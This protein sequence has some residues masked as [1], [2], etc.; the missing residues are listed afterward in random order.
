M[1]DFLLMSRGSTFTDHCDQVLWTLEELGWSINFEKSLIM[2]KSKVTYLGYKVTSQGQ[3][4]YPEVAVTSN[5]I[6]KLIHPITARRLASI[7][8]ALVILPA[9]LLLRSCYRLLHQRNNWE[10]PLDLSTDVVREL[11]WWLDYV[12][13]WNVCPV[14][15]RPIIEAQLVTNASHIRWMATMGGQP[16]VGNL[17]S[18]LRYLCIS[19]PPSLT[20]QEIAVHG[21]NAWPPSCLQAVEQMHVPPV[22]KPPR[23]DGNT[24]G[25]VCT[26]E[27]SKPL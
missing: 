12:S 10:S 4:G 18:T 5:R 21:G 16:W 23:A 13:D 1:D 11:R 17:P 20:L 7:A 26:T 3:S 27:F 19:S 6:R 14:V 9:K 2:P 25:L 24:V 15:V 22:I 8:M